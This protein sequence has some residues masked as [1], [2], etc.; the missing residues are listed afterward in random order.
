MARIFITAR[1]GCSSEHVPAAD[2]TELQDEL[3]AACERATGVALP[4]SA[5]VL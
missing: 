2:D 5:R 1:R 4:L 3:I